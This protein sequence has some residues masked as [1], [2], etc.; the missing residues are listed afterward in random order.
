VSRKL[1]RHWR[2]ALRVAYSAVVFLFV[3]ANTVAA[4][5]GITVPTDPIGLISTLGF[6]TVAVI[7]LIQEIVVPSGR[8]KDQKALTAEV[9]AGWKAQT[10]ATLKLAERIETDRKERIEEDRRARLGEIDRRG[11]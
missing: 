6:P 7:M 9:I 10:D 8:L 4:D 2:V 1:R 5:G 3:A 11:Q